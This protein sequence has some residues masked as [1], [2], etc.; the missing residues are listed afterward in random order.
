[1]TV[2]VGYCEHPD[3]PDPD[4]IPEGPTAT[5]RVGDEF[6]CDK[7]VGAAGEVKQLRAELAR[8][9]ARHREADARHREADQ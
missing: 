3:C 4:D 6:F 9:V 1:M 8:V 5:N 7:H 2:D